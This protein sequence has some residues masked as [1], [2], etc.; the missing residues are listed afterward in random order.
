MVIVDDDGE[1][2][3]TITAATRHYRETAKT[4]TAATRRGWRRRD[5]DSDK[6]V[7][8]HNYVCDNNLDA[9]DNHDNLND[10]NPKGQRKG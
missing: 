5:N 2:D 1:G 10:R 3:L 9:A 8:I 7:A 6:S 4:T